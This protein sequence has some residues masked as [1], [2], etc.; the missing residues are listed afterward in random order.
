MKT[1]GLTKQTSLRQDG[2][3]FSFPL[4]ND[5]ERF[6]PFSRF[7]VLKIRIQADIFYSV[8]ESQGH[9]FMRLA[10]GN[11]STGPAIGESAERL[12]PK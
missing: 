6:P 11:S 12:F 7:P 8:I 5:A 10:E 9:T 3:G 2:C 1:P 4:P